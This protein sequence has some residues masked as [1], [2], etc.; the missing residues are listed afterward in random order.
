VI[1]PSGKRKLDRVVSSPQPRVCLGLF[2]A[3]EALGLG[4]V[5]GV[6]PYLYVERISQ[7]ILESLGLSA[8]GADQ[9]ADI[10]VRIPGNR[11]SVFRGAVIKDGVPSSDILQVW[12][13]VSQHPS[14]GREQADL[15]W[16]R[17]LAPIF[18]ASE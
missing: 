14:R 13:D 11:E 15:I 18:E 2:A 16:R 17:V 1:S 10:Y 5:L 7:D 9:Q 8:K 3:A 6:Q 12:L 4:F